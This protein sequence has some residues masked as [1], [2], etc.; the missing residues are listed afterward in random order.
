MV[1]LGA[2]NS[3]AQFCSLQDLLAAVTRVA[4]AKLHDAA[5]RAIRQGY[6]LTESES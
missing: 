2:L 3:L 4:P 6:S 1:A 5:S